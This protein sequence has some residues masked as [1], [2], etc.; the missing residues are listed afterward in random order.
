MTADLSPSE[1]PVT[2]PGGLISRHQQDVIEYLIEEKRV[3]KEQMRGR[4]LRL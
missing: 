4:R 2:G 1:D 3:L